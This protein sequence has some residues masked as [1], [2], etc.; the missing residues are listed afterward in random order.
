MQWHDTLTG[1][2]V[3]TRLLHGLL[4]VLVLV[5]YTLALL[6]DQYAENDPTRGYVVGLHVSTGMLTLLIVITLLSW[7]WYNLKPSLALLPLWQQRLARLTHGLLYLGIIAQPSS[8]II[9]TLASGHAL[10]FYG[11]PILSSL[12]ENRALAGAAAGVHSLLPWL[13]LLLLSL[14]IGAALY[15]YFIMRDN[16]LQRMLGRN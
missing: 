14:H 9:M 15:H 1:Y 3:T 16:I 7:R 6:I 8:G 11:L 10:K 13:L 2:G 12:P 4:A 5:M